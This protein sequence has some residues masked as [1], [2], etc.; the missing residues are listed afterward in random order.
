[1]NNFPHQPRGY[2]GHQGL[3]ISEIK[4]SLGQC[5]ISNKSLNNAGET[6]P[7]SRQSAWC[8]LVG[9]G[10]ISLIPMNITHFKVSH[11]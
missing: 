7:E 8:C 3:N 9:E 2:A 11:Q 4:H 1:M 10:L 5:A 6:L